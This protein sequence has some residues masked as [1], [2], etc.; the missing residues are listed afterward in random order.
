MFYCSSR[1]GSGPVLMLVLMA[2]AMSAPAVALEV[3]PT[4]ENVTL[5][6]GDS[7]FVT[8]DGL[9]P[10]RLY[11]AV[12]TDEAGFAVADMEIKPD[13]PDPVLLW[14]AT[15]VVG[16]DPQAEPSPAEYRFARMEEAEDALKSRTFDLTLLDDATQ[17]SIARISL[18]LAARETDLFFFTD[19][20]GCPRYRYG[21]EEPVFISGLR[22]VQSSVWMFLLEAGDVPPQVGD[23]L[24]DVRGV[25]TKIQPSSS[26]FTELV[27][28]SLI[29]GAIYVGAILPD[30]GDPEPPDVLNPTGIAVDPTWFLCPPAEAHGAMTRRARPVQG[31]VPFSP[32][33]GEMP[34]E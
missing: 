33:A 16:C 23:P 19:E 11:R 21:Q 13:V 2:L 15:G 30:G 9:S 14:S 28:G 20:D 4:D 18:R 22:V 29:L 1:F 24:D 12:V 27:T 34:R 31:Q 6:I 7:L 25:P 17:T 10:D 32:P 5:E 8:R 26:Y 3:T